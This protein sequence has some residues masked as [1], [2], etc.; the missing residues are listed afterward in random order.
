VEKEAGAAAHGRP[1]FP[2]DPRETA[3]MWW[4][5]FA[6]SAF[7]LLLAW[8]VDGAAGPK[9][10]Q[11]GMPG[12]LAS[13]LVC[14]GAA[15][16]AIAC[17]ARRRWALGKSAGLWASEAWRLVVVRVTAM[18]EGLGSVYFVAL[19]GGGWALLWGD[20]RTYGPALVAAFLP[21]PLFALLL[22]LPLVIHVRCGPRC[23]CGTWL[24]RATVSRCPTCGRE[25]GA[26]GAVPAKPP[27]SG[28]GSAPGSS[29]LKRT[30]SVEAVARRL[31][32][33]AFW[34]AVLPVAAWL[35]LSVI[36]RW[37]DTH[38]STIARELASVAGV[39]AGVALAS[40]LRWSLVRECLRLGQARSAW[41]GAR[42]AKAAD[43]LSA[44]VVA[45]AQERLL[46]GL[47]RGWRVYLYVDVLFV[48]GSAF[49]GT[50]LGGQVLSA[51]L[52]AAAAW[53]L[54]ALGAFCYKVIWPA[55]RGGT[56]EQVPG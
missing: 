12:M 11:D 48:L 30:E 19:C 20:Q 17:R 51:V 9:G 29:I 55:W 33:T 25:L 56:I 53:N 50:V 8:A 27:V 16:G 31:Q 32:R 10:A 24:R 39:G 45:L 3:N 36:A 37:Q 35:M 42:D 44:Q 54:V 4:V 26:G 47:G 14:A 28:G 15:C 18:L 34:L 6:V 41:G 1:G 38:R 7:F 21:L 46:A 2:F 49:L 23:S 22:G 43:A 13:A 40:S 5:Y 52:T